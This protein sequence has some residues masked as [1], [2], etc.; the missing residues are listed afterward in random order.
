MELSV[1][2]AAPD[3]AAIV[4]VVPYSVVTCFSPT[5]PEKKPPVKMLGSCWP[6]S[7]IALPSPLL[8]GRQL[9]VREREEGKRREMEREDHTAATVTLQKRNG[10]REISCCLAVD[11]R[12][13]ETSGRLHHY[14]PS[15]PLLSI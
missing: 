15:T 9:A 11:D 3:S 10:K 13:R 5:S 14:I 2:V 8:A 6:K 1:V 12:K 7:T 4:A